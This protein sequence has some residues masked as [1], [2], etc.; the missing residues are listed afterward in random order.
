MKILRNRWAALAVSL[1]ISLQSGF[2]QT[3]GA[4]QDGSV[5]LSAPAADVVK[6]AQGGVGDAVVLAYVQNM[7][8][9]FNLSADNIIYLQDVGLSSDVVTAMINHDK[10]LPAQNNYN[11]QLYAPAMPAQPA[12]STP[13][14]TSVGDA[15]EDVGYFYNDLSPYGTWVNLDQ[16]GWCWQPTVVT[17]NTQWR[18]YCD[19][20]HWVYTDEGWFWSSDYSWGWAPFHYGRWIRHNRVGWVWFPDRVWGP[21]WVT[22][23][24]SG[25]DCG[26]APLPLHATFGVNTGFRFNGVS[27]GVNYDFGLLPGL[28]T[29]VALNDFCQPDLARRCLPPTEVTR[30]F[31]NHPTIINNYVVGKDKHIVNNGIP[32]ERVRQ[33]TRAAL[34]PVAIRDVPAGTRI[35][36]G[37]GPTAGVYRHELHAPVKTT[38]LVAQK[39]DDRHPAIQHAPLATVNTGRRTGPGKPANVTAT[40]PAQPRIEIQKPAQPVAPKSAPPMAV[41]TTTPPRNQNAG[42]GKDVEIGEPIYAHGKPSDIV[43]LPPKNNPT[44]AP[45]LPSWSGNQQLYHEKGYGHAEEAHSLPPL[46]DSDTHAV[47]APENYPAGKNPHV[48]APKI[49]Q[50]AAQ[51]HALPPIHT[52]PPLTREESQPQPNPYKATSPKD[53]SKH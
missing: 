3:A 26:W 23:R 1:V 41:K 50:N 44:P 7:Q 52:P 33:A 28:F 14:P 12:V 45:S 19:S 9:P 27:V 22:W 5:D 20:G 48:Y 35:Q 17:V 43:P 2:S 49:Q 6:M 10:N 32:V 16:Y 18:P 40:A 24:T 15:P 34:Q 42:A 53:S 47:P 29:F 36:T 21:A 25:N 13:P 37:T 38:A 31:N 46:K 11:Q 39:V 51:A 4:G 30:V 8:A